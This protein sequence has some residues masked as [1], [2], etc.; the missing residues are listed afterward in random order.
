MKDL[1]ES[2]TFV[3][4]CRD[5][6]RFEIDGLNV[7]DFEWRKTARAN[8][9]DPLYGQ[10]LEFNVYEIATRTRSIRFAAG[11]FS[12]NVWGFFAPANLE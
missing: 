1:G 12:N 10:A 4:S 5:G 9:K 11:E 2:W 6:V 8:V 7:W 3:G